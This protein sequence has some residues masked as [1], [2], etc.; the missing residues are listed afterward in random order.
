MQFSKKILFLDEKNYQIRN[1]Y[2]LKSID[3]LPNVEYVTEF[4]ILRLS[5]NS[6]LLFLVFKGFLLLIIC[7]NA[8]LYMMKS[9][10]CVQILGNLMRLLLLLRIWRRVGSKSQTRP[11]IESFQLGK[12]VII[13]STMHRNSC[14][15]SSCF[16]VCTV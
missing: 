14:S 13:Q 5:I 15:Q 6:L 2:L 10:A 4:Q 8:A 11:L 3:C 12:L 1:R 16:H 7:F 9:S